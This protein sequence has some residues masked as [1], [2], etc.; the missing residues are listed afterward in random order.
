MKV[1][2]VYVHVMNNEEHDRWTQTFTL[3]YAANP[4][5]HDHETLIVCN[6][7][8]FNESVKKRFEMCPKVSF[9]NHTNEGWDIGAYI[10]ASHRLDA[11]MVVYMCGTSY[12]KSPNWLARMVEVWCKHG[13]GLYGSVATYERSPHFNTTGFW[14]HPE[15][16]RQYPIRVTNKEE[17]YAFEHGHRACWRMINR[18]GFPT[19][20]A[21][22]DGEYNWWHWRAGNNIYRRGTQENCLTFFRHTLDFDHASPEGRAMLSHA[23]DNLTDG[24]FIDSPLWK[25]M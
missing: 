22:W 21:T 9:I 4:P 6:N 23:S 12:V 1:V 7:G 19:L 2:V 11:D 14:C 5:G 16:L 24:E 15:M 25:P 8:T 18:M 13:P 3:N 17:R 20:L 10:A